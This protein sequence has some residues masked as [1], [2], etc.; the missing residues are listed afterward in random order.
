MGAPGFSKCTRWRDEP[1]P[2][3]ADLLR[4]W[5]LKSRAYSG[6]AMPRR[7]NKGAGI[8]QPLL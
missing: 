3:I 1:F 8:C 2:Q 5:F 4:K 6:T 7:A